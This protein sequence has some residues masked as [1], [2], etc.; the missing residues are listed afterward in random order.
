MGSDHQNA[1]QISVSL[2]RDRSQLLLPAVESC[3]GTSTIQAAKSRTDR[4]AFGSVIVAAMAVA[5]TRPIP[6]M[7]RSRLLLVER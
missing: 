6:G 2:F 5:P 4:N 3:R 1:S 7:L